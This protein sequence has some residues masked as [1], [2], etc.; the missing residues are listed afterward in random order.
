VKDGMYHFIVGVLGFFLWRGKLIG[1]ENLPW[2]GRAVFIS[3]HLDAAGSDR[4]NLFDP[5]AGPSLGD[6]GHDG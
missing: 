1:E 6:R 4:G 5:C 2:H 3:N